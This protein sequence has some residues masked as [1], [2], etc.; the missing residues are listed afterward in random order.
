MTSGKEDIQLNR[1]INGLHRIRY[2]FLFI[3]WAVLGWLFP[4]AQDDWEWGIV[5]YVFPSTVNGRYAGHFFS[6][7]LTRS[8]PF[9]MIVVAVTITGIVYCIERIVKK[10]SAFIIASF[11][12]L[13]TPRAIFTQTISWASGFSNYVISVLFLL[14]FVVYI[15]E[16]P[17]EQSRRKIVTILLFFL[18]IV[19]SLFVEHY[20]V[21]NLILSAVLIIIYIIW[22]P[23]KQSSNGYFKLKRR[24][25]I[26]SYGL[27]SIVGAILMFSNIVYR[28]VAHN[29]DWYRAVAPGGIIETIGKNYLEQIMYNGFF[30]NVFLNI[31][32]AVALIVLFLRFPKKLLQNRVIRTT[33]YICI[34]ITCTY[35][36]ISVAANLIYG[37]NCFFPEDTHG[38]MGAFTIISLVCIIVSSIILSSTK[39]IDYFLLCLWACFTVLISPLFVVTPIGGRCF[40]GSYIVLVIVACRLVG[41]ISVKENITQPA[42]VCAM[43]LMAVLF[44]RYFCIYGKIYMADLERTDYVR[45]EASKGMGTIIIS[46]LPYEDYL[47]GSTPYEERWKTYYLRFHGIP[48]DVE[49]VV[50]TNI[51]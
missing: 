42:K 33:L 21:F 14:I 17:S 46:P 29:N 22:K 47:Y 9:K 31:I 5:K 12:I 13:L 38:L 7:T 25:D 8:R 30:R 43:V 44:G 26:I 32:I 37:Y 10:P 36:L 48:D 3:A 4:Y 35:F 51:N 50:E 15:V 49:L 27:G 23:G 34:S 28:D 20:T 45:E 11:G 16:H 1:L 18:G 41:K 40:F 24:Y 6:L 39:R 19:N 2:M